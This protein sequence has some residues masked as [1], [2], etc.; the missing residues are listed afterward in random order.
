LN[1]PAWAVASL[2]G[3]GRL[4]PA[5]GTWASAAVLPAVLLGPWGCL[6]LGFGFS[7]AGLWAVSRLPAARE[8]PGWV[9]VDEAAGQC[10]ALACLPA[11][12]GWWGVLLAF[13]LFRAT[14]IL[15]PGPIGWADRLE[16]SL[17]VML[18][19]ILAGALAGAAI[20]V[21]RGAGW[22]G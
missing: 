9:V 21:L 15:K 11:G 10:L 5:P 3:I 6:A 19:D 1:G 13:A 7:L 12:T 14:D 20:L 4:R 8:D 16:G 22:A 2:L 18:D 17:G